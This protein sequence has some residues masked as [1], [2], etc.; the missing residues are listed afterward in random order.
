M[1]YHRAPGINR[2]AIARREMAL[3]QKHYTFLKCEIKKD[4]LYCYGYCKP[5]D[6]CATYNYRIVYNPPYKPV[7]TVCSPQIDYHDDIHMY[8]N[9]NSLCLYH[10][11][12]LI[13]N[14][15]C[16]LYNTIIPWTQEWFVF[17]ELWKLTGVWMHPEVKHKKINNT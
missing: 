3:L 4:V 2:F 1:T 10:S 12:D 9:D 13:W 17:Y 16:H 15:E 8:H 5:A 14:S 6:E 11:T 7:V